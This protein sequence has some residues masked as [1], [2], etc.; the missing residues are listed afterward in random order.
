MDDV[1]PSDGKNDPSV[2]NRIGNT[3]QFLK[4]AHEAWDHEQAGLPCVAYSFWF[5]RKVGK[6]G[7]GQGLQVGWSYDDSPVENT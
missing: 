5:G 2:A 4:V 6:D 1:L 7:G 3:L